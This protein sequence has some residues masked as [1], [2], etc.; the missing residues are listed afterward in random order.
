MQL[1]WRYGNQWSLQEEQKA[2]SFRKRLHGIRM[3]SLNYMAG[4]HEDYFAV[5]WEASLYIPWKIQISS[6][7]APDLERLVDTKDFIAHPEA[8]I[9]CSLVTRRSKPQLN[10]AMH[11]HSLYFYTFASCASALWIQPDLKASGLHPRSNPSFIDV[12]SH[13]GHNTSLHRTIIKRTDPSL[14]DGDYGKT[15]GVN[16]KELLKGAFP[17]VY[18][19]VMTALNHW[20]DVI[21]DHWFPARDKQKVMNVLGSIIKSQVSTIFTLCYQ[22]R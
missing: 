18:T 7:A 6:R 8:R 13:S 21:F 11:L 1:S 2:I 4:Q 22:I 14:N 10:E 20:D 12:H 5:S 9:Y 16:R 15:D 17:D 19:L 3:S